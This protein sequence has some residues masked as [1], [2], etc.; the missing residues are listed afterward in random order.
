MSMTDGMR[1]RG[2]VLTPQSPYPPHQGT[3]IRNYNILRR[4]ARYLQ[5]QLVTFQDAD[6]PD[7]LTTPLRLCCSSITA[8][9]MPVRRVRERLQT[10]VTSFLPDLAIRLYSPAMHQAVRELALTVRFDVVVVEGLEM[11]PYLETF[12]RYAPY[13]PR[14]VYD[15]H[16]AEYILQRRAFRTDIQ[17][18]WRWHAALYSLIQWGKLRHYEGRI[19]ALADHVIAVSEMDGRKLRVLAPDTP[20]HVVPNGVDIAYYASSVERVAIGPRAVVFT[21]KMDYRPNVDAVLWFLRKV[22]PR[23]RREIPDARFYVVGRSPHPRLLAQGNLPGVFIT[24]PV[25]DVRP[26]LYAAD[27][28]VV[29]MRVGGGTRLKLLEAMA[30]RRAIV[31]TPLGA[32][33]YPVKPG[34]HLLLAE[35]PDEFAGAVV[36]LLKDAPLRRQLGE[37][38]FAFAKASYDWDHLVGRFVDVVLEGLKV[39][40]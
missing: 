23:V 4:L 34:V 40:G 17:I 24:G 38:A 3:S 14:I 13:R 12:L 29:P 26:Y 7:P 1:P 33:G 27:V 31:S 35:S 8:L 21:G 9:P 36:R 15:A 2:L 32:E 25:P 10:L 28:F 19:C 37:G 16:N 20:V 6:Q 5:I 30:T 18:P 22:W 39:E 11:A